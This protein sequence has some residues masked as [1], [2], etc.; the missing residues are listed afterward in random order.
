M[1]YGEGKYLEEK[2]VSLAVLRTS[3]VWR[4]FLA[5]EVEDELDSELKVEVADK[6]ARQGE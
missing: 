6:L 1:V 4:E 5:G 2:E 3:I